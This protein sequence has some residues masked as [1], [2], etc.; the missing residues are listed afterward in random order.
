[1]NL[2]YHMTL[3]DNTIFLISILSILVDFSYTRN[4]FLVIYSLPK[5]KNF[6]PIFYNARKKIML[7]FYLHD[8]FLI[9]FQSLFLFLDRFYT[10]I[11]HTLFL[12]FFLL[13]IILYTYLL[14]FLLTLLCYIH[15]NL[16]TFS[17]FL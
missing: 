7:I 14:P 5:I 2:Y 15:N 10:Y 17:L 13:Q 8:N 11:I 9:L 1:M 4:L 3:L 16:F 12:Y 6:S